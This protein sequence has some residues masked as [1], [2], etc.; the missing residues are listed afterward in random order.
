MPWLVTSCALIFAIAVV[1]G[2][3]PLAVR[4]TER[5]Q[6]LMIAFA[7]GVFLGAVFLH[8]LPEVAAMADPGAA[9]ADPSAATP[10]P[11]PEHGELDAAHE[12]EHGHGHGHGHIL[13]LCV[14]LGV[15]G[16]FLLENLA[17]RGGQRIDTAADTAAAENRARHR[18]VGWATLFGLSVHSF[19]AGLG[20]SAGVGLEEL[21]GPLL[22]SVVSHKAVEGFSLAA[23][24]LLAG[25]GR[26]HVLVVVVAFALVTPAGALGRAWFA[27]NLSGLDLQILAALAAGTFLF[28]ALC[29]LLPEVFHHKHDTVL[30]I[31]LLAA[32]IAVDF[33][34][35]SLG[36]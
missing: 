32:G 12:H 10:A 3:V 1:G 24:L 28:V 23:A 21:R 31:G 33:V 8:L 22:L 18:T 17:I 2:A 36:G 13:W 7:A 34:V 4:R 14:L 20:L 27:P 30:K 15:V 25:M 19:T 5:V 35:H 11:A 29:D 9:M 16:L 26:K 6:H